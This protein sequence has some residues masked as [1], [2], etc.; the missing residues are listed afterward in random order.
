LEEVRMKAH[1]TK[2][3][4]VLALVA[5]VSAGAAVAATESTVTVKTAR[6]TTLNTSI[7][8]S[9]SGRTLYHLTSE[10]GKR[11]VC[12]GR[13][14]TVWLPLIVAKGTKPVAG[15]GIRKS[16]LGTVK[17]PDGRIQVTYAG[18][19]LYRYAS[20]RR[21]G[22]TNGEGIENLWY[23]ISPTGKLVKNASTSPTTTTTATT[24]PTPTYTNPYGGGYG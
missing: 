10:K 12:T 11:F 18:M 3:A 14:S 2:S 20:D 16:K 6:N 19:T 24:T 4:L 17:R 22:Q 15:R 5:L 21:A 7:V 23:A 13:C 1:P 9:Q 8:V